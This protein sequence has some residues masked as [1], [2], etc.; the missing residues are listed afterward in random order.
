[1]GANWPWNM[2][3]G[4]RIKAGLYGWCEAWVLAIYHIVEAEG[5]IRT[6]CTLTKNVLQAPSINK[7]QAL[8]QPRC[9][10]THR[11]E[12][13]ICMMICCRSRSR[14]QAISGRSSLIFLHTCQDAD[15]AIIS[16]DVRQS[17][18]TTY[19]GRLVSMFMLANTVIQ[20][21]YRAAAVQPS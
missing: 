4:C 20:Q 12:V 5:T 19:C 8:H 13:A 17:T 7:H 18:K 6:Q 10:A 2:L 11:D 21:E 3:I 1:M 9:T 14:W 15:L 16:K